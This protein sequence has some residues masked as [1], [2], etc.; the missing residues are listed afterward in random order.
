MVRSAFPRGFD[1]AIGDKRSELRIIHVSLHHLFDEKDPEYPENANL[2]YWVWFQRFGPF[3]VGLFRKFF[4][5]IYQRYKSESI[6]IRI[7]VL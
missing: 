1:P 5:N 3:Y 2:Q 7:K 4:C 6:F